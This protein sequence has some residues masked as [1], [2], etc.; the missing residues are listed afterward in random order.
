ML[1]QDATNKD[2]MV[3][4]QAGLPRGFGGPVKTNKVGGH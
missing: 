2:V 4:V 1:L 3:P